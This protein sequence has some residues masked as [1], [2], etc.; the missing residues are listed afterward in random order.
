MAIG[1][2]ITVT[3]S[4]PLRFRI[5]VAKGLIRLAAWL[6]GAGYVERT[7]KGLIDTKVAMD[8]FNRLV[9]RPPEFFDGALQLWNDTDPYA[10]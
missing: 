9:S 1:T 7:T 3:I 4:R 10:D 8:E 6:L 2:T 5:W